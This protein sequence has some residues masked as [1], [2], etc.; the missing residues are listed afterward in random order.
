[1]RSSS[2]LLSLAG[3][4][5]ISASKCAP[6]SSYT[7]ASTA[8]TDALAAEALSRLTAH[9]D[10]DN[11]SQPCNSNNIARRREWGALSAAERKEYIAAVNCLMTLPSIHDPIQVPGAKTRYDD[12]VA[13]H[14]NQTFEIHGTAN[15]L[16]WHRYLTW[17]YEKALREEC[18]YTG[19]QPYWNWGKYAHDPVNSPIFDGSDT[20]MGG[21]GAFYPH[22]CTAALNTGLE[23][24]CIPPGEG[25]GCVESGPFS[26]LT[27]NM[28]LL[29]VSLD[30]DNIETD[31]SQGPFGYHPRC[32]RRDISSWVSSQWSREIDTLELLTNYTTILDFQ[33][34]M[35][36]D[37][38]TGYFGVHTAGHFTIGGDPGGDFFASNG[39]PAFYL[40]HG[41]IDRVWWIWQN[42]D[43]ATRT[44]AIAG[45]IT[46]FD[47]PPSRN[48]TLEDILDMG[49][50]NALAEGPKT[51]AE[52]MSTVGEEG[53][54]LCYVYE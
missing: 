24:D 48:G 22:N 28:G 52:L 31:N 16:S 23:R 7:P 50:N 18:G 38:V 5:L 43:P 40:H 4:T 9:A 33:N 39:D 15:F 47:T 8:D 30:A 36:G 20:S 44:N 26:N 6:R 42:L 37:F 46:I 51:I 21:N 3:S 10:L 19:Y 1:M 17:T 14:I 13:V 2:V 34:R 49:I 45:T 25:G 12:F 29:A 35:Q 53:S 11:L 32:L 41:M 54:P 27:V